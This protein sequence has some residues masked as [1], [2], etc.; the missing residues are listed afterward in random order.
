[1]G[2]YTKYMGILNVESIT[3]DI[4]SLM[5]L[6]EHLEYLKAYYNNNEPT[7]RSWIIDSCETILG[8]NGCTGITFMG[9]IKNYNNDIMTM[10]NFL[11]Q[12]FPTAEGMVFIQ[13]EENGWPTIHLISEGKIIESKEANV[14]TI[15][16][17]NGSG[18]SDK[19][20]SLKLKDII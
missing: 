14:S 4:E 11:L 3:G 5:N 20:W 7:P 10:V 6:E 1:M 9:E 16:Y 17:G 18:Y 19:K 8:H 2:M 12:N 13:Y 15:G